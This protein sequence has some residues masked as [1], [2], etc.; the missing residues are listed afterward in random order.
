MDAEDV[1]LGIVAAAGG[2]VEGRTYLQKVA[3]FAG[4][5]IGLELGFRPHY[6]GP[7]SR[8]ISAETDRQ[9]TLQFLSEDRRELVRAGETGL[10]FDPVLY[11]YSLREEGRRYC[12]ILEESDRESFGSL[13]DVVD[14]IKES[15]ADYRQLS[16]AAKLDY[17]LT[18][19]GGS[20]A[21][22]TAKREARQLGWQLED[23][24]IDAAVDALQRMGLVR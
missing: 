23:P 16:C 22:E 11:V 4:K 3:Y 15:G 18:A 20:I 19:A 10:P 7:Y 14:K 8:L 24:D 6:Y 2:T 21:R 5:R 9:V 12:E 13:R 17:L 1:V